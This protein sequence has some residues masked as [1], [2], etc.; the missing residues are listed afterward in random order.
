MTA[1][2]ASSIP[3][4]VLG[5]A[6]FGT[7]TPQAK[8]NSR[9]TA[10][11]LLEVC[12]NR[13]VLLL[14]SARA[15]PVG[16]PGSAEKLLGDLGAGSWATISTKVTSWAPGSHS[17]EK[18]AESVPL[19]LDSLGVD[20]VDIMYL[21]SPDRTTPWEVTAKAMNEQYRSGNFK[22]FGLS[23]YTA[24]EISPSAAGMFTGN[25][26]ANSVDVAGSRWDKNTR[27]GQA[28]EEAYLKPELIEAA[29]RVADMAKAAGIGGHDVALRWVMYHSILSGKHGDAVI[30]GCSSV[31]Q[32]EANLN[33]IDAGPL[34]NDLVEVINGVWDVVKEHAASYHL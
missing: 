7:G 14:D 11:P 32:M 26:N 9:K 18:I 19:S 28:Y 23:N 25:I 12:Q 30:L 15:Y 31:R 27:L 4:I 33:A 34:S 1:D 3:A 22:R 5:T 17:A 29:G 16:N 6:S 10:G 2:A 21:H 8:F 20:H 24:E 13:G